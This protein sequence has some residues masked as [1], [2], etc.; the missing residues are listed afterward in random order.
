MKGAGRT[1]RGVSG[2]RGGRGEAVL[3]SVLGR[4]A[5]WR[6]SAWRGSTWRG[7]ACRGSASGRS[8]LL[9]IWPALFMGA[10]FFAPLA[11]VAVQAAGQR[12]ALGGILDSAYY[13]GL[14]L[15][16]LK[17]AL[18]STVFSVALGLPGAYLVGRCRF[19]GRRILKSLTTVP[20][21][22]PPILAVLG[23]VLVFGN[24]GL[25]NSLRRMVLGPEAP[26][27]KM[28]Y[29]LG[30]VVTAHV[31]FNFP[32]T[33]RIAG[34]AFA[35]LPLNEARAASSLG[36]GRLR[37][38]LAVDLPHLIPAIL[39]ATVL[40]FLYC[41]MSFAVVLVLGGGPKLTTLEVEIFR[42]V[43]YQLDFG[44]GSILA[45]G[46]SAAALFLLGAYAVSEWWFRRRLGGGSL[47]GG[48]RAPRAVRGFGAVLAGGVL[49][50]RPGAGGGA[51]GGGG[52]EQLYRL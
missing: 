27:W 47:S 13:R 14:M 1:E 38:F 31:F 40:T 7:S 21:V 9:L 10:A 23:F 8:V 12:G 16:T 11:A 28:L 45:L 4:G 36:A 32:L 19:P 33:L 39:T 15:F 37:A 42:L 30:A 43:K 17:Q 3:V 41:F 20:F 44:R 2:R 25:I 48:Q 18:L 35:L 46:G 49:G 5:A 50:G 51:S 52:G 26:P 22:L 29:S 6:G 34:D 24:A